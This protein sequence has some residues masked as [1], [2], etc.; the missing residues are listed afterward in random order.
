MRVRVWEYGGVGVFF[1]VILVVIFVYW[2]SHAE[3]AA[4][5]LAAAPAPH[6]AT[7]NFACV[8]W[9]AQGIAPLQPWPWRTRAAHRSGVPT[10]LRRVARRRLPTAGVHS[11]ANPEANGAAIRVGDAS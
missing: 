5:H 9:R 3:R 6:G 8:A 10:R 11:R 7:T 1:V 2:Q 4:R